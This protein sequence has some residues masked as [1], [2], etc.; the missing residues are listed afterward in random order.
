[1]ARSNP[2]L[3]AVPSVGGASAKFSKADLKTDPTTKKGTKAKTLP[4][5][6][7][8]PFHPR[9]T[10]MLT[11]EQLQATTTLPIYAYEMPE[12][13][14]YLIPAL[15]QV[16]GWVKRT[17]CPVINPSPLLTEVLALDGNDGYDVPRNQA[18]HTSSYVRSGTDPLRASWRNRLPGGTV[19]ANYSYWG[20]S[21]RK[22]SYS[23]RLTVFG[24][25][26]PVLMRDTFNRGETLNWENRFN[27]DFIGSTSYPTYIHG[28]VFEGIHFD[29]HMTPHLHAAMRQEASERFRP[30]VYDPSDERPDPKAQ[31]VTPRRTISRPKLSN[32]SVDAV[33]TRDAAPPV[34]LANGEPFR[35]GYI[36]VPVQGNNKP[37]IFTTF[38]NHAAF[39]LALEKRLEAN[40]GVSEESLARWGAVVAK[41]VVTTYAESQNELEK[42]RK[43][44]LEAVSK[45]QG[46]ERAYNLMAD[47]TVRAMRESIERLKGMG[48]IDTLT[49]T[50][51]RMIVVT[52]NMLGI[53]MRDRTERYCGR[54]EIQ[55]STEGSVRVRNIASPNKDYRN[56]HG[57]CVGSFDRLFESAI[58]TND[59][60]NLI[61][62]IMEY[63][64]TFD[65][66]H[67]GKWSLL[68]DS[69]E[70]PKK[71]HISVWQHLIG[72]FGE[73]GPD[74]LLRNFQDE[75][76]A[77]AGTPRTWENGDFAA[78][79]D[80]EDDADEE[81]DMEDD[82][83]EIDDDEDDED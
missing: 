34:R 21:D 75:A 77:D 73:D 38:P 58:R 19:F 36:V 25:M 60:Y 39:L 27:A 9:I 26:M 22:S 50:P 65:T 54:F 23:T 42:L 2:Y 10:N 28:V 61:L 66:D 81:D 11:M 79:E 7:F 49:L 45:F 74:S 6:A 57:S 8:T 17:E 48:E 46:A 35:H 83:G 67:I 1:M 13:R 51:S 59:Y 69:K 72:T 52:K 29:N 24:Y 53:S 32:T 80:E 62:A 55:I 56:P 30:L 76:V 16:H 20:T 71:V 68:P 33:V 14:R 47:D 3:K 5:P 31:G 12:K 78:E 44:M 43:K 41:S 82:E 18:P 37:V 70:P 64:R 40:D 15:A 4:A 63:Y